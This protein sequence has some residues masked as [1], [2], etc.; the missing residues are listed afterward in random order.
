MARIS[1]SLDEI[2]LAA[3]GSASGEAFYE[4][5]MMYA[6]GRDVEPDPVIAH[7]WFNIA[8]VR[9]YQA[10]ASKRAEV[11]QEMTRDQIALAQKE[12]RN[13]LTYH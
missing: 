5:G 4:L 12:A 6:A 1:E 3:E 7:K 9:G 10:A 11:A 13:W 2:H 8:V